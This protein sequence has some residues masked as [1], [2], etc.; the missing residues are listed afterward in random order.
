MRQPKGF[1]KKG[2]E[3]LV[4]KL[5]KSIYGLK[6]SSRCWN[7]TLH[8]HL[9]EMGFEQSTNDPCVYM[10]SGGDAFYIGVYMDDMILAGP[11]NRRIKQVKQCLSK[12]VDINNLGKLHHFLGI[13]VTQDEDQGCAWIA[14]PSYTR[15]LLYREVQNA[16]LQARIHT[17]RCKCEAS[18]GE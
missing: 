16:R 9:Q 10:S 12:K 7:A 18:K 15:N 4:C 8:S 5:K 2:E 6:Q 11:T 1:V 13:T 14:Q 17:S 3:D